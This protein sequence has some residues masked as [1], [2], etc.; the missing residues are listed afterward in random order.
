MADF[1]IR[2]PQPSSPRPGGRRIAACGEFLWLYPLAEA[3]QFGE[4]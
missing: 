3:L 4:V 2:L 1:L